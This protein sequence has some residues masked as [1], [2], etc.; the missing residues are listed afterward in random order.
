MVN[1]QTTKASNEGAPPPSPVSK[2]RFRVGDQ[3]L[4]ERSIP[5]VER[6]KKIH[7]CALEAKQSRVEPIKWETVK[8]RGP[9]CVRGDEKID[10]CDMEKFST[11]NGSE[12]AI[13]ILGDRWWPRTA[14]QE[15]DKIFK[16][17]LCSMWKKRNQ[18]P[19]VGG[20]SYY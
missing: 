15:G 19:N 17:F 6:R 3:D 4:P 20:V 5:V 14:K 1:G 11:L 9:G 18:R 8:Y 16:Y 7:I 10:E 12:K 13:A 2:L